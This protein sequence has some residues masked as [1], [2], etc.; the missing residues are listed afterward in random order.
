MIVVDSK[1]LAMHRWLLVGL[2]LVTSAAAQN[3]PGMDAHAMHPP[4]VGSVSAPAPGA[5][6]DPI[7]QSPGT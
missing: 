3:M 4:D 6:T 2:F 5:D 7:Y 1:I